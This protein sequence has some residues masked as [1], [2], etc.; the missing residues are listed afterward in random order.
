MKALSLSLSFALTLHAAGIAAPTHPEPRE[1]QYAKHYK[2]DKI[3]NPPGVD[4]QIGGIAVLADGRIATAFHHGEI[5]IYT[6]RDQSWKI[7]AEGLHEPLGLLAEKDGSLLVMQR[8]ELTRLRDTDGDGVADKYDALWADF[9]MTGNYHEFA[10]GP[11]RGPNGKLY[12]GLNLASNGASVR[13]EVRGEWSPV[14]V[15]RDDFYSNWKK[16]NGAAGRM[17]SRTQWRGWIMEVDP[18]TGHATPYAS[19]FRSPDGIAF[20]GHDNLLV[21]DNEGDWRGSSELFVVKSG[22]F[23]GHPASLVWRPDWDGVDPLKVPVSRLEQMRTPAAVW[24]PHN[25]YANSPTAEVLIPKT[26]AWGAFGGQL[27]VGEMNSPRLLR[28]LMEEVDGVW[29][30]GCVNLIDSAAL[31]RGLHRLAFSADTLYIGRTHLSWAG[32]EGLV[33]LNPTGALPFDPLD[34]H[35]TPKGFRVDF[36]ESLA[37]S[38]SDPSLWAVEH[39]TYAYHIAYG[40]PQ[41][42]KAADIPTKVTLCNGGKTAEIE[43]PNLKENFVYDLHFDRVKSVAGDSPL[44]PHLAYT[45]RKIPKK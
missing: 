19:G 25:I 45:L 13:Q 36:T 6:P 14:G 41:L 12:V 7:F 22:G 39:Y 27:L 21:T 11:A 29:Q 42:E 33:A 3:A 44:N 10:F 26:P 20:D 4:P 31:T 17:Y 1:V 35:V 28:V 23:Y 37:A 18:I 5:Y 16:V 8:P 40:S 2:V 9:G 32:S 38:A 15:P 43:L 24:F 34:I 30:G